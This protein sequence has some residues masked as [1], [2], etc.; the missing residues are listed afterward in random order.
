MNYPELIATLPLPTPEQTSAF[1]EHVAQNHSW[2]KHLPI[3][4]PGAVFTFFLNPHAGESIERTDTGFTTVAFE[5]GNYFTHHSRLST[6]EY[7]SQFGCWDYWV[8]NPR[9]D[10]RGEGPWLYG[11]G[12][13][14]REPLPAG[15]ARRWSCHLTAFLRHGP[16][17][18]EFQEE[19]RVFLGFAD[20]HPDDRDVPRYRALA[21][22]VK[23][24]AWGN[25]ALE[26]F[27]TAEGPTQ[28]Q[29][30]LQT[31][32]TIRAACAAARE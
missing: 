17:A 31:L 24:P 14:G 12:A 8:D 23:A 4:P 9:A 11:V 3:F 22:A 32:L 30:V 25:E 7:R 21:R 18:G 2:Y 20:R 1:A 27:K 13:T 10:L 29:L 19:R 16:V 5:V 6:P 28:L 26:S 15:L